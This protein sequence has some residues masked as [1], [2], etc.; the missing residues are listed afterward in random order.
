MPSTNTPE[1]LNR[2]RERELIDLTRTIKM[3]KS[4]L[5]KKPTL[6]MKAYLNNL[7]INSKSRIGLLNNLLKRTQ[8]PKIQVGP[9]LE[10]ISRKRKLK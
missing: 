3:A 10:Q 9:R 1:E 4:T 6:Q 7:I 2:I 5:R 8:H